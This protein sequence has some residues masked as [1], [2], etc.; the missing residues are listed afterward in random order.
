MPQVMKLNAYNMCAET[1]ENEI[2]KS[3]IGFVYISATNP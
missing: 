2:D 3:K 1:L